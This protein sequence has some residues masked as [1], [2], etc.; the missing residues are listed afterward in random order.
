[1]IIYIYILCYVFS[2]IYNCIY[3]IVYPYN[4]IYIIYISIS[5]SVDIYVCMHACMHACMYVPTFRKQS[6]R[7]DDRGPRQ[8]LCLTYGRRPPNR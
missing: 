4:C 6:Y 2:Y 8:P 1:M 7:F 5:I 3:I